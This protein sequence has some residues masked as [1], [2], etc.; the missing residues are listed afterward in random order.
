MS[1]SASSSAPGK[2][3]EPPTPEELAP[4]LPQ[5]EIL[6]LLGRGGMGAVYRARQRSLKREV[7]IKVLPPTIEDG[8]MQ[9]AER[10]KAEAEAMA[11]LNHPGV[12]AV[13]DA[14]ET[15]GGLL[16]IVMEFVEGT[17]VSQM[18]RSSGKLPPDYAYSIAA[19]VCDALAYAHANGLI[20]RDIK[21]ANIMVD[22]QG[23]V[24][25]ADFG[26]A[27]M[28]NE[29]SGFT[30][31]NMA[32]GTPDF[33]APEAFYPG[34][35]LDGRA[36]LYAVG[37]MLYQMLTGSVP[38]GAFKPASVI[39]PGVDARFDQI[40]LK[41]MQVDREE[42]YSSAMEL[43]QSLDT[44][45][46]P[47]EQP[48][49]SMHEQ[50]PA[51]G[52]L[53]QPGMTG[54]Q[55]V[56]ASQQSAASTPQ[57]RPMPR[58]V[59][60]P[61]PTYAPPPKS[62]APLFLGLTAV[63]AVAVGAFLMFNGKKQDSEADAVA[64]MSSASGTEPLNAPE[65]AKPAA[66]GSTTAA[67]DAPFSN[68]LGMKFVPVEGTNI[69]FCIHEVRY[70]DYAAYAA[71]S[72][73]VDGYWKDQT[74]DDYALTENK[75]NHP[76]MKVSW[77][78]AQRFCAW[79]SKKESQTYRLPTDQEWSY[80]VGIGRDE[81]WTKD[82]TPATVF[83][84]ETAFPWGDQW[85]P[86]KGSGNYSDDSRKA[87][88]KAPNATAQYLEG[89]DDG[90]P[91]TAP[92]MSF[93][94]NKFGL[95]DM[96]GNVW[97]WCED[98][99]DNALKGRVLRG[100]S[101][102]GSDR[103]I[104]LSSTRSQND[105]GLRHHNRG[106]RVVF[107]PGGSPKSAT[108]SEPKQTEPKPAMPV[109]TPAVPPTVVTK[110]TSPSA[111]LPPE[112]AALDAQFMQL[113][114]ERV[115]GP[116]EAGVAQL[117][118]GYLG[119]ITRKIAE[120]KAA[121]HLDVILALEAEQKLLSAKQPVPDT[122]D[123]KTPEALKA[124]RAI[125]RDAY[126][127]LIA[128]RVENLAALTDPL[129]KRLEQLEAELTKADRLPDAKTVRGYR[130]GLA[131]G[132]SSH[133]VAALAKTGGLTNS[134]GMKFIPVP[135]TGVLFCI[136]ETRH[137]D[138][139]AYAEEVPRARGWWEKQQKFGVPCGQGDDEPVVGVTWDEA[140]AFCAWLSKKEGKAYRLPTD[141]E[142]SLAAGI[143]QMEEWTKDATPEMLNE[144]LAAVFPWGKGF[145]PRTKDRAGNYADTSWH[146]AFPNPAW[147]NDK[148]NDGFATTAPVMS[149]KPNELGLYDMG[150]NAS[151][152]TEDWWND[153]EAEKVRRGGSLLSSD[154]GGMLSSNRA[155][156]HPG[157]R[158]CDTGFRVVVEME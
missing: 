138:Y 111:N 23:R 14:G 16:Y 54:A 155:H 110:P 28:T 2:P 82:T 13:Y 157:Y 42:R 45:L 105:P 100:G 10:F 117:N 83:R 66:S 49:P 84:N 24:K 121:G 53:S 4:E 34:V 99:Y 3:W 5:Y 143:G 76:V 57:S 21:P 7:A 73:G 128:A 101:W 6:G 119:G 129:D 87:K 104:L 62:K 63:A 149:F 146:E 67:K 151:E 95:Y 17:D 48:A 29:N 115:T 26:L 51:S 85:P 25:V 114:A 59:G 64:A 90:F 86:P 33:V 80:A 38:R 88:A 152:W 124:L 37:V 156:N 79:L 77:W 52:G 74:S 96:G 98:W 108:A 94:P 39:V 40:V 126:A 70:S 55:T 91:T 58:P 112:L 27:K 116:F 135:G 102:N 109:P 134:L 36:D 145:P 103:N 71:E 113:Q 65:T 8:G 72:P 154:E 44:L 118:T 20:H 147:M 9:F 140:K 46:I 148:Y 123:D 158:Y 153:E 61:R 12:V 142:W 56:V 50:S 81:K 18:I 30:Q 93:K 150:G 125:Y 141:R 32:V 120:E 139:T 133:S 60:S 68:S 19:H 92:V 31:T 22:T 35:P 15:P 41:A 97:E 106:F 11:R 131:E 144:K 122:D 69:L 136:H 78:D 89:Y 132:N 107:V 43:R 137:A 75:E 47:L 1:S 127:K 130:E